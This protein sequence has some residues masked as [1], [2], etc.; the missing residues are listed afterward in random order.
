[1]PRVVPSQI[2]ELIDKL[3]EP[4]QRQ[5]ETNADFSLYSG[6][7]VAIAAI[8]ALVEHLPSELIVLGADQ[9]AEFAVSVAGL[10]NLLN[11]WQTQPNHSLN[12][13]VGLRPLNPITLIR[14]ALAACPDEF[15]AA[16]TV[17][18][19]F[20]T[21]TTLRE[22]LRTDVSAVNIALAGG[23]WKAATVIGGSVIEALLLWSL[24][25]KSEG[26][27]SRALSTLQT[28]KVLVM[29]PPK[30]L[31]HLEPSRIDRS[32]GRTGNN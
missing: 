4:V 6:H 21:D 25:S 13:I 5:I 14:Q 18:L 28:N 27:I 19:G 15:P 22:S 26:N 30:K 10:R 2:V 31:E 17:G 11:T 9:Y 12:R 32:F 3:F 24:Q 20:V 8:L 1:V 29:P 7:S 23:E 16:G